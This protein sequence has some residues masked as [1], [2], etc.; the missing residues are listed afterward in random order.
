MD[1]DAWQSDIF[2]SATISS[3][4]VCGCVPT[5]AAMEAA[6]LGLDG[7][8][9]DGAGVEDAADDPDADV[10]S[11]VIQAGIMVSTSACSS[12]TRVALRVLL[13]PARGLVVLWWSLPAI[14]ALL[15]GPEQQKWGVCRSKR[16]ASWVSLVNNADL[17]PDDIMHGPAIPGVS[18]HEPG[19]RCEW[20]PAASTRGLMLLLL[21]WSSPRK[22]TGRID[23]IAQSSIELLEWMLRGV[24]VTLRVA[25][26]LTGAT[27]HETLEG[28]R[29]VTFE[30]DDGRVQLAPARQAQPLDFDFCLRS[31]LGRDDCTLRELL[32]AAPI[33]EQPLNENYGYVAQLVWLLAP[34]VERLRMEAPD[35]MTFE[36]GWPAQTALQL[37]PGSLMRHQRG[38]HC[39]AYSKAN[40][41]CLQ[42]PC[43][44]AIAVDDGRA[45]RE[46]W[47][48][49][50]F[51]D[52]GS[53]FAGWLAPQDA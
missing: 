10:A 20:W 2:S 39:W 51:L 29:M 14:Y 33:L 18:G 47:K 1:I 37:E 19:P 30:V 16:W 28:N 24:S 48:I 8:V 23:H 43:V 32:A 17:G 5:A 50:C 38:G 15:R 45:G 21:R 35:G 6:S 53:N 31:L 3:K 49:G 36:D 42:R 12:A 27:D 7:P 44:T 4:T 9:D 52:P 22:Q 26:E 46:P 34:H 40:A 25:G 41:R 13:R 11:P